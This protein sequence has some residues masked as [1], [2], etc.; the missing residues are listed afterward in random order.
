VFELR[1]PALF[2]TDDEGRYNPKGD[3][4]PLDL[5]DYTFEYI[6]QP[7]DFDCD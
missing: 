5:P 3:R 1:K 7:E 2:F 6:L 4:I